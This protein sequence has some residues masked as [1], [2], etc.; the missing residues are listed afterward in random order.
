M[1]IL[2]STTALSFVLKYRMRY[3][4]QVEALVNRKPVERQ[5]RKA[6]GLNLEGV[7]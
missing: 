7:Y 3:F 2:M 6:I 5:G 4:G 1:K